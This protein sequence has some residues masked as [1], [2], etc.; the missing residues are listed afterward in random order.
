MKH[1]SKLAAAVVGFT[2]VFVGLTAT[3]PANA[4][5]P[6]TLANCQSA[7]NGQTIT[8]PTGTTFMSILFT[9]CAATTP[10]AS[11]TATTT[12]P[13]F[14]LSNTANSP[15][16]GSTNN[17]NPTFYTI[18]GTLS[19]NVNTTGANAQISGNKPGGPGAIPDGTY[20]VYFGYFTNAPSSYFGSF[21]LVIGGSGGAS[22]SGASGSNPAPVLQQFGKPSTGT[23]D[24]AR[25]EMLNI[26]GAE[27]GGWGESWAQWMNGGNGGSVCTR[28]LVYSNALGHWVV[29]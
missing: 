13:N 17:A 8:F 1:L 24:A 10:A 25:P 3:G 12:N 18:S 23:C 16:P 19:L 2:C 21:T 5:T 4:S 14:L 28:T 29:G 26:G 22:S 6:V 27:S 20:T 9:S 11:N 7:L 15:Q